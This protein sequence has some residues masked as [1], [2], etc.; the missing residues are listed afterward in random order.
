MQLKLFVFSQSSKLLYLNILKRNIIESELNQDS[1]RFFDL[2]LTVSSFT[3]LSLSFPLLPFS[4]D[5]SRHGIHTNYSPSESINF[6]EAE[7]QEVNDENSK[8]IKKKAGGGNSGGHKE[9]MYYDIQCIDNGSGIHPDHVGDL[10]GRVL[11]GSKHGIK[12]T[13]GKFG[14]GAKMALIW[15]KKSSGLPI[16]IR[17]AYSTSPSVRPS[18]VSTI[19]LDMDIR[20]N[21]PRILSKK[22]MSMSTFL[23]NTNPLD[24]SSSSDT[25]GWSRGVDMTVT[26]AGSWSTTRSRVLQ[27]FQ[28]LAV[29]TPYAHLCLQFISAKDSKKNFI[30][31]FVRRFI[32]ISLPN[33]FLYQ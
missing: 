10:L 13:R 20:K 3:L 12:Q 19:V 17:T 32:E 7:I 31:E 6:P 27:Y 23:R 2:H 8:K 11:S 29:I 9:V 22:D 16:T 4:G 14:L 5:R 21:E 15:S 28:Q 18:H 26:I 1:T 33:S 30:A 25:E 24:I